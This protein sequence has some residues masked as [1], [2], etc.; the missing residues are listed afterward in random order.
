MHK[1]I[2]SKFGLII[3][4]ITMI[5]MI[6]GCELTDLL[7]TNKSDDRIESEA[8]DEDERDSKEDKDTDESA[9]AAEESEN[10]SETA[11]LEEENSTG[12]T[13]ELSDKELQSIED[14]L[15]DMKFNGFMTAEFDSIENIWWDDVLYNGAGI[16]D[17]KI[18]HD[19]VMNEY[20]KMY[21]EDELFGDMTYI[22]SENLEK[23]VELTTGKAYSTMN[24]PINWTYLKDLDVYVSQHGDTN[25]THVKC[26]SG[27]KNGSHYIIEYVLEDFEE[28]TYEPEPGE[29]KYELVMDKTDE[30]YRFISNV[31]KPDEGQDAA[32]KEIYKGIIEKYASAVSEQQDAETLRSNN[33]SEQCANIYNNAG[34]S[35]NPMNVIGYYFTDIDG[36]GIDELFIGAN[37]D[38]YTDMIYDAYSIHRGTWTRLFMSDDDTKYYLSKDGTIYC[39]ASSDDSSSITHYKIYG[40]YKFTT[41]ID[42]VV[43]SKTGSEEK[44]LYSDKGYYYDENA[45]V[46]TKEEYNSYQK[47]ARASYMKFKYTTFSEY[48]YY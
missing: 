44:W 22:S 12:E 32:I 11:A 20:L 25:Y 33:M 41:P 10:A 23:Y 15:N 4:V 29:I 7:K 36:D 28:Y 43:H 13:E 48:K 19:T 35:G 17:Q 9:A 39:E 16:E 42:N 38:K 47:K 26:L 5:G 14:D 21:D 27:T 40:S 31:W 45:E 1:R 34:A 2:L 3:T 8:D 24:H 18:D 30:G 46:I 37:N 6:T